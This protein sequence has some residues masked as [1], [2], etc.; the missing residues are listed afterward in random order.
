MIQ[1]VKNLPA[2]QETACCIVD[3]GLIPGLE[4]SPGG[5]N[6]NPLQ[7]SCLGNPMHRGARQGTVHGI[8]RIRHDLATK[9]PPNVYFRKEEFK[10]NELINLRKSE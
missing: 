5:G 6:G 10:I 9:P 4:R 3:L 8:Q 1:L 2:V 7:Y